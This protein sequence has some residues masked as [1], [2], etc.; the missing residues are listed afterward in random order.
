VTSSH[1]SL[2]IPIGTDHELDQFSC[3]QEL[4]DDWLKNRAFKNDRSRASKTFVICAGR[5]VVGFYC[6]S[7]GALTRRS[8]PK[9]LQR[10]MPDPIPVIVLG[11]L[12]VDLGW[13]GQ[14]IGQGLLKDALLRS[15]R[16]SE[17]FGVA[18]V[19]VHAI[20]DEAKRFYLMNGFLPSP[21]EP[22]TLCLPM[23]RIIAEL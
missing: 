15:A 2:P 13:Q 22:M 21:I 3:G 4:L 16:G 17:L 18:A 19:L 12:A 14:G 6:L 8:A 11:R 5:R 9:Q 23:A 10:N 20:S 1:L 7:A